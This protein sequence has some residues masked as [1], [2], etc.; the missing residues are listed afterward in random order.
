MRR[1]IERRLGKT[2]P[3]Q[4]RLADTY[5][6]DVFGDACYAPWLRA[7]TSLNSTFREGWIPDN[8]YGGVVVPKLKGLYGQ[9]SHLKAV[10]RLLFRDDV[11][12]DIAYFVNGLFFSDHQVAIPDPE[13]AKLVF[14]CSDRVAF[15]LDQ[16]SQ[17]RG[18]FLMDRTNFSVDQV[19][20]LGNGVLQ[21]FVV[22]HEWFD[23]FASKA[24]ATVRLTSVVDDAGAVSLRA[25]FLR[26]GRA[27]DT[28]IHADSEV[29]VPVDLRTGRLCGRG[30]LRDWTDLRAHPDSSVIFDGLPLPAFHECVAKV[31]ELQRKLPFARCVGWDV[32]VDAAGQVVVLEWNAE[33]N[34]VKFS[35]AT[36]G[37]CFSDL[38][39]EALRFNTNG[40]GSDDSKRLSIR[41]PESWA[42]DFDRSRD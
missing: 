1:A 8:Y 41:S 37:P 38:R 4:I 16:S 18:V 22:Q 27:T 40:A 7:Y 3:A 5:A 13:V 28:Y 39:W 20:S 31:I 30:Y 12:P 29:C 15:K 11:F 21:R 34:D 9:M 17:G 35:E 26:L 23:Q 10:S 32:T 24:V 36:Q 6:L 33:H 19:R 14:S 25:G 42:V 2:D